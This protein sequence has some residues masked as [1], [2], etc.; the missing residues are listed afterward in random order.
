MREIYSKGV[1][2]VSI[3]AMALLSCKKGGTPERSSTTLYLKGTTSKGTFAY[4]RNGQI[5]NSLLV[6][7]AEAAT[8]LD[9]LQN[10]PVIKDDVTFRADGLF[11]WGGDFYTYVKTNDHFVFR[12]YKDPV[13]STN[14]AVVFWPFFKEPTATV[15]PNGNIYASRVIVASGDMTLF[16][17]NRMYVSILRRDSVTNAIKYREETTVNNEFNAEG[18]KTLGKNDTLAVKEYTLDYRSK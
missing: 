4:T 10:L 6:S 7:R 8:G 2:F 1:T 13:D 18:V 12:A 14:Y 5:T 11:Q 16:H 17:I 15:L 3:L 9:A